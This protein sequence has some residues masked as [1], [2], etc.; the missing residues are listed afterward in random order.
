MKT[1]RKISQ[2]KTRLHSTRGTQRAIVRDLCANSYDQVVFAAR[3]ADTG[4]WEVNNNAQHD[5]VFYACELIMG[6]ARASIL[7]D[8]LNREG[9]GDG[10]A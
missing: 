5:Q 1:V 2:V 3:R 7:V 4:E 8:H 9:G 10:G 6:N